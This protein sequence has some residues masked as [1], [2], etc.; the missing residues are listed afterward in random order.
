MSTNM[1]Q[2][3]D[4]TPELRA[5]AGHETMRVLD[6][7]GESD[8]TISELHQHGIGAPAQA[9]YELQLAGYMIDRVPVHTNGSTTYGYR[10]RG[11][12]LCRGDQAARTRGSIDELQ[13]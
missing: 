12:S 3:R 1:L 2:H 5:Q 6:L 10:L 9:I 13:A 8:T 4:V 7:L 11:F